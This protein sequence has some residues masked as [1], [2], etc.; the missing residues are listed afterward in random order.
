MW[1]MPL[2]LR[3]TSH[4]SQEK[5]GKCGQYQDLAREQQSLWNRKSTP[6][7]M[8]LFEITK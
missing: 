2:P 3:Q 8:L 4:Q 5:Q 7:Y 1:L 6:S